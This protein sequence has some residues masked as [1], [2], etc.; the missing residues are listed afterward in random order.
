MVSS[1]SRLPRTHR[2]A[3]I[4]YGAAV[5]ITGFTLGI[6]LLVIPLVSPDVPFLFFFAAVM[7][8]AVLGGLGA[9]LLATGLAAIL[10][11]YFFTPPFGHFALGNAAQQ[12]RFALF[13]GE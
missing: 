6:K 8:S 13:M 11:H 7:A 1:T 4:R 12:V 10:D 3:W 9:G 5:L 2:P